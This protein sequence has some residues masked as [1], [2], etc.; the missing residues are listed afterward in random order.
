MSFEEVTCFVPM[1]DTCGP[2]W[3][4]EGMLHFAQVHVNR[5]AI[6]EVLTGEHGWEIEQQ[7]DG[8]TR[9]LCPECAT[10]DGNDVSELQDPPPSHPESMTTELPREQ[11]EWLAA[12]DAELWEREAA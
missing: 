6:F 4:E 1:C 9:M 11:E 7:P 12:V 3:Q 10:H 2:E 8:T 5:K